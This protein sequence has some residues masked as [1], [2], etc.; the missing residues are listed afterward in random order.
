MKLQLWTPGKQLQP[1]ALA[2]VSVNE[3]ESFEPGRL[4]SVNE[5]ASQNIVSTE[6]EGQV[7]DCIETQSLLTSKDPFDRYTSGARFDA[8]RNVVDSQWFYRCRN[9]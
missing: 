4:M 6:V 9:T 2:T 3:Q 1:E 7:T 5:A 8:F